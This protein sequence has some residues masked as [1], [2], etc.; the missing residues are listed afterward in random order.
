MGTNKCSYAGFLQFGTLAGVELLSLMS[1]ASNRVCITI[2][3]VPR[4]LQDRDSPFSTWHEHIKNKSD[5]II[6]IN[7]PNKNVVLHSEKVR[8]IAIPG[9]F[10]N[11]YRFEK[12]PKSSQ[13]NNSARKHQCKQEK[14]LTRTPVSLRW[15]EKEHS[16]Y[17]LLE[18]AE[19][20]IAEAVLAVKI[21]T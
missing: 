1:P 14:H 6:Y 19:M 21:H 10:K 18:A 11:Q 13:M 9:R 5:S 2:E 3:D 17:D 4:D 8:Q 12:S 16:C 20:L 15:Y 7:S